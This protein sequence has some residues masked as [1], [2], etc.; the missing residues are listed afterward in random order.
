M[1]LKF[2]IVNTFYNSKLKISNVNINFKDLNS[3]LKKIN[4]N[5]NNILHN[6]NINKEKTIK[7]PLKYDFNDLINIVKNMS[8]NKDNSNLKKF[9]YDINSNNLTKNEIINTCDSLCNDIYEDTNKM[10]FSNVILNDLY[11]TYDTNII[12]K[13]ISI[14]I[15]EEII[16]KMNTLEIYIISCGFNTITFKFFSN[17]GYD[18]IKTSLLILKTFTILELHNK[19]ITNFTLNFFPTKIKKELINNTVNVGPKSINSGFTTIYYNGKTEITLFREEEIEK[20]LIHEMIH[21]CKLDKYIWDNDKTIDYKFKCH[22]NIPENMKIN[23][24]EAYTECMAVIY[25][26][27]I[28]SSLHNLNLVDLLNT[29]YNFNLQQC[30]KILLHFG[31]NDLST[32]FNLEEC[33]LS[34]SKWKEKT[35][36]FSYFILKTIL[37]FDPEY[38]ITNIMNEK[39]INLDHLF[40]YLAETFK[41]NAQFIMNVKN[42]TSKTLRMTSI[43]Y[44]LYL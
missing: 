12:T 24:A 22:F 32:F 11:E 23:L 8:K 38:F 19:I 34:K 15:Q 14:D 25:H 10:L 26:C 5:I 3:K 9:I 37:L 41:K 4:N 33:L 27:L 35:S 40:D 36:V 17:N 29:E 7:I 30:K 1:T 21:A 16:T 20:V 44:N 18:K 6:L 39:Y 13:F 28:N 43:D 31:Y 2:N 42:I